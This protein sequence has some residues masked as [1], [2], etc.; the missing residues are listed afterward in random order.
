MAKT[1][2]AKWSLEDLKKERESLASQRTEI[3]L[4]QVEVEGHI[5]IAEALEQVPENLRAG[6]LHKMNTGGEIKSEG[7][8]S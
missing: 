8:Q 7:A 2:Y 6:V 1:D 5:Q 3:R 4:K